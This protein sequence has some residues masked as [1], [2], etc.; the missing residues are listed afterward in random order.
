M[1]SKIAQHVFSLVLI[2]I[3]GASAFAEEDRPNILLIVSEDN[4]QELSCYGD[5][6][7]NTPH[8]DSL[9]T[10]GI[11][12]ENAYVTQSVCSPS[13]G[14][15][16]T[17]LMPHQNGQIGLATHK[18]GM[19][20]EWPTSYSI[21][22]QAGYYTGLLGKTHVNPASAVEDFV[23]YRAIT[24]SNFAK[25]GLPAYASHS[26]EFFR[27]AGS[28]PFFLTVNY[29]DAHHPLQ[30]QVEGRPAKPLTPEEVGSIA[31]IGHE[32]ERMHKIVA[33]YYN[34][35]MR[36][37]ECV[38]ELL[39]QLQKSGKVD[40]TIVIYIGDHGAQLPRGKVFATEAGMKIPFLV[41]WPDKVKA[42]QRSDRLVSTV[43]LL[44]TFCEIAGV[45]A[46]ASLPGRSLAPLI[47]GKSEEWR[48]YVVCERN[49][50]AVNLYY[51]QRTIRDERYKIIWS[52]LAAQGI[53]DTGAHDYV[54][55]SKW[56]K[57]SY[58]EEELDTLP[59]QIRQAYETWLNP[60]EYQLYDL[61]ND[62]WEFNNL[63][64]KPE[65]AEVETRLK[66]ALAQWMKETADWAADPAKLKMLTDEHDAVRKAGKG[67]TPEGG[68]KYLEYLA[69]ATSSR[70]VRPDAGTPAVGDRHAGGKAP[71]ASFEQVEPGNLGKLETE[72]GV[73]S[74]DLGRAIVDDKH[75]KAGKQCLQIAGGEQTRVIL[76]LA[77]TVDTSGM[78]TFWAERWTSRKPFSFRIEKSDG[79]GW[80]EIFNGDRSI[81]VGRSFRSHVK[82]PLG[83]PGI[84][85]LRFT[86]TSPPM[87]GVLID[88][89]RIGP[90]LDA[91]DLPGGQ[92]V[93]QQ[94]PIPAD[95]T[96]EGHAKGAKTYGYRIP[97]LLATREGSILAFSERRL[98]LHDHAQNDIVLKR[99]IDNGK[100]W[101]D[102]IV[103]H[104]DGMNSINDPLTVQLGN[105]RVLLMFA[106]FPYGR[107]AR[108]AG[109]IKMADL[110]YDDPAANVLT[111]V[112][113]SDDD[114]LTWSK[115]V[116]ISRQ[117]KLPTLLNANTPGAM[118]QLTR[119]P[120]K[121]RVVTGLWGTL[122]IMNDGK[123]SREWQVVAAYS[124]DNGQSWKRTEPLRDES[125]KGFPNECQ[126]AEAANGTI[127]FIARNQGGERFRK[128]AI[129][130]DGGETWSPLNID[131][132]LPSVACM[133]SVIKGPTEEDGTWDLWASF[134]SSA[135][136]KDGQIAISEDNGQSWR[137]VKVIPGPF[138]YSTL[139]VSPD[140]KSLLCLYESDGYKSETLLTIPFEELVAGSGG[141]PIR[142]GPPSGKGADRSGTVSPGASAQDN[143]EGRGT[144]TSEPSPVFQAEVDEVGGHRY[145]NYR[146]PVVV[147][148]NSGRLI[149][150]VQA[151]NRLA[152]PERSGQDLVVRLSDDSGETW[153]PIIV[154]AE[155][156]DYSCQ[157]HGLVYD[158]AI[159]RV[160]F[161]Y[162]VYNWNY[163]EVGKGRG[164][165]YTSP[166][167]ERMTK[168]G[169]PLVASYRVHSDDEG[170]TWSKPVDIT[171]QV[172]TQAHFGASEGRQLTTGERRGRLLIAGSR[173]DL[174]G[175]GTI[176]AKHIGV[177]KSDDHGESWTLVPVPMQEALNTPRNVSSEA[178]I[179]ELADGR[180]LYNQRTRNTGRQVAWSNDG[181]D[182]WREAVRAPELK[183]T[184]CN[185]CIV[186]LRD[187][188]GKLTDTVLFSVPSPGGRSNGY[189]Y[190]SNDGGKTWPVRH[191]VVKGFFAYTA[192]IQ[193]DADT[194]GLFY[195]T[196]HYK[197]IRFTTLAVDTLLAAQPKE[198]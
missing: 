109:W 33:S 5:K 85:Q 182:T 73:W 150:G 130:H 125:G 111:F 157:C 191:D 69:P 154:A 173:M 112:C 34:C 23:D 163:T 124:D 99:S 81:R 149:V 146:E 41:K 164:S 195:E 197:D 35:M 51:P 76:Q 26:A 126:V 47:T 156:G 56:K 129:S 180:L 92:V 74:M 110:G 170:H 176:T 128:K 189:L 20:E 151:G 104:E 166:I 185:G 86:V 192:L 29:P 50:D 11:L 2:P 194:V 187:G 39:A 145:S 64:G 37:D 71:S 143:P 55:Q 107:H 168:E 27:K 83:D 165:K 82:V 48:R 169:R 68:W 159:N 97:S 77:E 66:D 172:S 7:V 52:P 57:C 132:G 78:L 144:W 10:G 139:Q 60:P 58:S 105:G 19:F 162:T 120:H 67:K 44:P 100:S 179:T 49:C 117:V 184:Q 178:R 113:H 45:K 17:G 102:E 158:A 101:S 90:A 36:L 9:A 87:T 136:R 133:G 152:W 175:T 119:G 167:Y 93:F 193:L 161:L 54:E 15:I 62:E 188:K 181:G 63:A 118:I 25:K 116:D 148:T 31:Y 127:V 122:P 134:P 30:N 13:R 135:G 88:D 94:R 53:T 141:P 196:N 186:T 177:W 153:S 98:G 40:N 114:G 84:K 6:N 115:P 4:G 138:A 123:R 14:T 38:G 18:Y 198:E 1:K 21:L 96:L 171:S 79:E 155:H 108:D 72:I 190:V 24:G 147:R 8:L 142:S 75:A 160:L 106:R 121:G 12:F 46:R 16:F 103:V 89:V 80:E 32:N 42:G 3:C 131:R 91:E 28:K 174:D 183:A 59:P 65:M 95:V 22:Q 70:K 43:D 61:K 140:Q 137:I